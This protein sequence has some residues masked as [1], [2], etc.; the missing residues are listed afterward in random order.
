MTG[1][2]IT[3]RPMPDLQWLMESVNDEAPRLSKPFLVET[4]GGESFSVATNGHR[5]AWIKGHVVGVSPPTKDT[6]K[7]IVPAVAGWLR[8]PLLRQREVPLIQLQQWAANHTRLD[9]PECTG[10]EDFNCPRC[11]EDGKV[12]QETP[13]RIANIRMD[14][15]LVAM[16]L[17]GR[18]HN[19]G[20]ALVRYG[21]IDLRDDLPNSAVGI[22]SSDGWGVFLMGLMGDAPAFEEWQ[23]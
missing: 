11:L 15:A 22:V 23:P 6:A 5:L 3:D 17:R 9:C 19:Q 20:G 4:K 8:L 16:A 2:F 12:A 18:G 13:S 10:E 1:L 7:K 14:R 21:E